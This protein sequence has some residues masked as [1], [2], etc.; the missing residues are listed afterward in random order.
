MTDQTAELLNITVSILALILGWLIKNAISSF[1]D[2]VGKLDKT[3][4]DLDKTVQDHN[5]RISKVE[6]ELERQIK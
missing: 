3:L 4:Q 1:K 5:T 2:S 6:W